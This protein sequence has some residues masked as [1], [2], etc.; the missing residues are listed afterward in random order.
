MSITTQNTQIL[1]HLKSGKGITFFEAVADFGVTHLPRRIL[2]LKE[3]GHPIEDEWIKSNGK[4]FKRWTMK[5]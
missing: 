4:R 5:R 2:D 1:N 3:A